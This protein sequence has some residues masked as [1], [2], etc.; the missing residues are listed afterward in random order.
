ME[1]GLKKI[2]EK[3]ERNLKN[4]M[5]TRLRKVIINCK[6]NKK[7][8]R[9]TRESDFIYLLNYISLFIYRLSLFSLHIKEVLQRT[10]QL[11]SVCLLVFRS[12]PTTTTKNRNTGKYDNT[13][14]LVSI[15]LQ[16]C[17]N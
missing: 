14:T 8:H 5:E 7:Q 16:L 2:N 9:D 17:L 4:N 1:V 12:C 3:I 13:H 10:F 15:I 11:P 6:K